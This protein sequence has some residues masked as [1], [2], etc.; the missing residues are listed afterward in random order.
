MSVFVNSIS[1][2]VPPTEAHA[3]FLE[4]IPH[5]IGAEREI[6]LF[7][8]L[9]VRSHIERRYSVLTAS[10]EKGQLDDQGFYKLEKFPT[11]KERM[12]K[13]KTNALN[14]ARGPVSEILKRHKPQEITHLIVT[15]CTGF[16]APGL[17]LELQREFNLS[18]QLERTIIGF[19]GCYA[20]INGMK[21][22]YHIVRS[23]PEA[24]VLMVNLELCTL[25]L[26]KD[27]NLEQLLAFMQFADGCAASLISSEEHGLEIK[28]FRCEVW[29]EVQELIQWHVGDSGFDMYLSPI[30]PQAL[31]TVLPAAQF[32]NR[33]V[34]WAIHPG[35]RSILDAAQGAFSLSDEQMRFSRETLRDFG[36]MSSATVMFV[37]EKILRDVSLSGE[38]VAM[39]F[40]PGITMET[41]SFHKQER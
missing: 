10:V 6:K 9:A 36:N 39:A 8:R 33:P 32:E 16:Y 26:Q 31:A 4:F 2:A 30:V 21:S 27:S 37:L 17:D 40:G 15:S 19:M 29:Q 13:Y 34:L 22:A 5:I 23:N 25:H 24:K 1:T 12:E 11:T 3:K 14:L 28:G 41:M 38:G 18:P 20:A 35:G 7:N